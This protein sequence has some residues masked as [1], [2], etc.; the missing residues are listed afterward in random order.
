MKNAILS[1]FLGALVILGVFVLDSPW[2][3]AFPYKVQLG[4]TLVYSEA[5]IGPR[6]RDEL[7]AA[8]A[9]LSRSPLWQRP[10]SRRICLTSGGWRWRV[11]ALQSGDAFGFRRP[12]S[13]SIVINRADIA[14]DRVST[15]RAIGGVRTLSGVIAHESTHL[16]VARHL[17]E[18]QAMLLPQW[19]SE[20]YA[21]Y[22]AQESSLSDAD[23]ARL[24]AE[25]AR[26]P[27]LAYY[28]FRRRVSAALA[29]NGGSVERL[30]RP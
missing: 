15:G 7:S 17:G 4:A 29:Q 11:L 24:R 23:A 10:P 22:V 5:P 6:L 2:V 1:W 28:E 8:D 25:G 30:L 14:N 18:V 9:L 16:M 27:A 21:D 3:L 12:F 20:G 26:P 13:Q 19:K